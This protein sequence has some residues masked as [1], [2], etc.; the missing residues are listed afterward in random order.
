MPID[1]SK[2]RKIIVVHGVQTGDDKELHQ[3]DAVRQLLASRLGDLDVDYAVDLYKYENIADRALNKY[4][5]LSKVLISNTAGSVLAQPIIDLV[6]DVVI[7]LL[8]GS[9]AD[10]IRNGLEAKITE[11][12]NQ[13][14]P[15]YIVA[16]S[17]GTV[18]TFDV[19][20]QLMKND[21]YFD[22]DNRLTWP[23]Q[24]M[25]T[26]GSPLGL[27]MFKVTGRNHLTNIGEGNYKFFWRNYY[28]RNDPVVSGNVFG[29]ALG[30]RK[31]A[32]EYMFESKP[33]GWKVEDYEVNTGKLH[34]LAHISYW[35]LS[36]VGEGIRSMVVE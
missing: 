34:L 36:V 19:V 2:Q 10:T 1:P 21:T 24:G 27:S 7:S 15:C 18:Y 20:N 30:D 8:Q 9:T 35:G 6:G 22:P 11:Y 12:Y 32:G 14:H 23:V 4:K 17:L 16:H 28:D 29:V 25:V 5:D 13:G 33:Q 3:D 31:I 26:I